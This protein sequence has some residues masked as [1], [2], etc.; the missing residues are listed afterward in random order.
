M[1][2]LSVR[3]P[4]RAAAR[5]QYL[6]LAVRTCSGV[7]ATTLNSSCGVSKRTSAFSLT[8]KRPISSTPKSQT[9]TD[10]FPAPET[11]N[12]K[13]VQTAWVHPVYTEAQMQ[14]IQI[15]HRQ[16]ANWSDWI[17]LG[18][19][20]FF[21]WGMDTA[22]G[23]KHPK[24]GEELPARF[25]MTEHKWLNR[26]VFLES[27]AG[28][29]GMVGG[30]LRHLRSLRKMKRDNGW[31]ETLLEEAF[32]ERMHL[33]TFLKLAEPGWFMRVMVIGAQGVF[34]N[35]FFLSY[36]ISPRICHRFVGYLE[37][38]AVITYT[39]AIEELEAGNLPEWKDLDAPEIAVKYWQMPEGQRKMKDLLLFIRA[40]EAKHREV[41]HTLA[42]L[43]PTQDPNPYQIEYTDPSISHPTKGIDNLRPEGWD[44]NE[45]FMGKPR[46]E[47]S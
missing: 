19:V 33:L 22:T 34:F 8:S 5:P 3:A 36:L 2:T 14:S 31:I 13:E 6:H 35:G 12:V 45:I 23:Y 43:K 7:V 15:A 29:P 1:N 37:E 4:L 25:K 11:P 32:N 10:Y 44:R 21:R 24:P 28:V 17:A 40:D 46:T 38:E 27:I 26:F 30:M 18:T 47:K 39:R 20:R 41:N 16:T 9:I 42:N